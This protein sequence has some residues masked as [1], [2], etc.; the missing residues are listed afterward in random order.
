MSLQLIFVVETN[1][2]CKSDWIYIKDTIDYFFEYDRTAIKL[3]PVYMDGKG[4]YKNKEKE[5]SKN[6]A[7]YKAGGKGRQTKVI[8]CFD[9]D[10]YNTKQ[11]DAFFLEKV[12]QYCAEQKYDFV[13]FCKDIERVYTGKKVNAVDKKK[14]SEEF[15][16]KKQISEVK[17]DKLSAAEYQENTSNILRIK[18]IDADVVRRFRVLNDWIRQVMNVLDERVKISMLNELLQCSGKKKSDVA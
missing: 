3:T 8:Y 16:K 1:K 7:A 2:T 10:D 6:I 14:K 5:I 11:E 15:K 12:R 17:V 18:I 13:W 4:K 9:C